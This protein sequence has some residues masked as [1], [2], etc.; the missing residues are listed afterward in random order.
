[1]M[2]FAQQNTKLLPLHEHGDVC[3]FIVTSVVSN[4]DR[5][6]PAKQQ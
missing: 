6:I 4:Y 3:V 1:V 2:R 5:M